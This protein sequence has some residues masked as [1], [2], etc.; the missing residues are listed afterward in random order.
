MVDD[1]GDLIG[2]QA[3]I[4]GVAD[5][6]HAGNGE[7]QFEMPVGVPGQSRH[8]I[9]VN[10]AEGRQ[11]MRQLADSI[12]GVRIG[13]AVDRPL[14]RAGHDFRGAVEFDRKLDQRIDGKLGVHHLERRRAIGHIM[15]R[16]PRGVNHLDTIPSKVSVYGNSHHG[17]CH[18][19]SKDAHLRR[20]RRDAWH[21]DLF[22]LNLPSVQVRFVRNGIRCLGHWCHQRGGGGGCSGNFR[23]WI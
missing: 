18:R 11:G 17:V 7:I 12:V 9:A 8:P 6:A 23:C 16:H 2:E 4:D 3:R 14:H 21:V 20:S 13:V 19:V 10:H 22:T 1:I 15:E 5:G